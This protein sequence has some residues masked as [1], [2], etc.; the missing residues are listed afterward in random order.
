MPSLTTRLFAWKFRL[1]DRLRGGSAKK[2]KQIMPEM[3]FADAELKP[4]ALKDLLRGKKGGLLWMTNL[5]EDCLGRFPF[6]QRLHEEFGKDLALIAVSLLGNDAGTLAGVRRTGGFG[7]P[8]LEDPA[9]EI[10][11][12]LGFPHPPGACPLRNLLVFDRDRN[13][14][15][16]THLSAVKDEDLLEV[17]RGLS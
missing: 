1:L 11:K 6:Y 8:L 15:F 3:R 12:V 2:H 5:C 10:G 14:V 9:D 17:L 4:V 16:S 7:F 13:V